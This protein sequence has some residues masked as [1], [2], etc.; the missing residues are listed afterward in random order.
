VERHQKEV[1]V[2]AVRRFERKIVEELV[3]SIEKSVQAYK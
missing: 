3:Q 2:K 1:F